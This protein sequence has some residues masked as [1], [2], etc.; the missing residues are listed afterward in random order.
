[1]VFTE[2][3]FPLELVEYLARFLW[4]DNDTLRAVSSTCRAWRS[5]ALPYLYRGVAVHTEHQLHSLER[6]LGREPSISPWIREVRIDA[7]P[8]YPLSYYG[9]V[10]M[11]WIYK[12]PKKL[13]KLLPRLHA[14]HIS[15]VE[16]PTWHYAEWTFFPNFRRFTSVRSLILSKCTFPADVIQAIIYCLP[17]LTTL[18]LCDVSFSS[19][20]F[21]DD[22]NGVAPPKYHQPRLTSLCIRKENLLGSYSLADILGWIYPTESMLTLRDFHVCSRYPSDLPL[23]GSFISALGSVHHLCL[24]FGQSESWGDNA[25]RYEGKQISLCL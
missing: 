20:Q 3:F 1:M 4:I 8:F 2:P 23:V 15:G 5:I 21:D 17:Q 24:E 19:V 14:I 10:D 25:Q 11:P 9:P 6:R 7:V 18:R 16:R 12:V 22:M 13:P